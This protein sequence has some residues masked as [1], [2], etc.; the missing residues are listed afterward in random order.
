MPPPPPSHPSSS[1]SAWSTPETGI[2][3]CPHFEDKVEVIEYEQGVEQG[4]N[5]KCIDKIEVIVFERVKYGKNR[6]T[7]SLTENTKFMKKGLALKLIVIS[8]KSVKA[9]SNIHSALGN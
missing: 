9:M 5:E 6:T 2:K 3:K 8:N 7:K 4:M 1:A